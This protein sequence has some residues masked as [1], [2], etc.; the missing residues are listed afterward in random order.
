MMDENRTARVLTSWLTMKNKDYE[1]TLRVNPDPGPPGGGLLTWRTPLKPCEPRTWRPSLQPDLG[2]SVVPVSEV[3]AVTSSTSSTSTTGSSRRRRRSS[4][5]QTSWSWKKM[6]QRDEEDSPH[7]FTVSYAERQ[8]AWRFREVTF[9]CPEEALCHL[10]VTTL[11]QH[12]RALANRPR[13]LLVYINPLS[14]KRRGETIFHHKVAPLF[15][16]ANITTHVIVTEHAN[17]ARD[18]LQ[19]EAELRN[20]DGVVCVGGD[21]M[22]SEVMHG[23]VWR[24]QN[25]PGHAHRHPDQALIPTTLRIGIIP[26]GSTDCICFATVGAN[27]PVTSALHIIVGDAQPLDVCSVHHNKRFLRYSVSLL[28]YGFY[29]DVLS[30]SERKRW[31]GPARYDFSGLKVFLGHRFYEGTV[32]FLPASDSLGSP[33][34]RTLC[35]TGCVVCQYNRPLEGKEEKNK[36]E[37]SN[38]ATW[39]SVRGRFL[40]INA[41]SMSCACP[42]S[43]QGL[44][45]AAHLADGTTDLILVRKCSRRAFLRH[46]LR[47]TSKEDQ[48][49]LSFVEVHRVRSFRFTPLF[50]QSDSEPDLQEVL[51]EKEVQEKEVQEKEVAGSQA[52][53]I[54][55]QIC[56]KHPACCRTT[57]CSSCWNCDGEILPHAAIQVRVHRQLIRL[58]ARGIEEKVLDDITTS[59]AI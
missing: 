56:R 44:S 35:R 46:L 27:D 5:P 38:D 36:M 53:R 19:T 48:F 26:A 39:R 55:G 13:R 29:G 42:R 3:I 17:H 16:L 20:Y 12:I 45:P 54:L 51:L 15:S 4:R 14:G 49:D 52:K 2:H 11:T 18:H 6:T 50:C 1:V 8:A 24:T 58:F 33:R 23:L 47:H 9:V 41:V 32:S 34:D 7:A 59:C 37:E 30:D 40:A 31:M 21:G 43:P 28:G 22:F 57:S 10:W 25:D